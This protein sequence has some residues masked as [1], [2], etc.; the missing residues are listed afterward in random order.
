MYRIEV[1]IRVVNHKTGE[2][3]KAKHGG[4]PLEFKSSFYPLFDN[5]REAHAIAGALNKSVAETMHTGMEF[6][7]AGV[8]EKT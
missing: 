4:A 5:S 6:Y 8:S 2:L 3:A 7:R 1:Q